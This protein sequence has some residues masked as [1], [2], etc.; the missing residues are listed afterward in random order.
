MSSVPP[1][2][3]DSKQLPEYWLGSPE[4]H[5]VSINKGIKFQAARGI[6]LYGDV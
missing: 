1:L 2:Y 6:A 4:I 5:V 3:T